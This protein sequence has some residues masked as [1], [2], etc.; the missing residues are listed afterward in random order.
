MLIACRRSFN[1]GTSFSKGTEERRYNQ[2][3]FF[4]KKYSF[5][6]NQNKEI[7]TESLK[8]KKG[9]DQIYRNDIGIE[10]SYSVEFNWD[11]FVV[12]RKAKMFERSAGI[13]PDAH[14][15]LV[16][17]SDNLTRIDVKMK[18][19]EIV[20][21]ILI[22]IQLGIIAGCLFGTNVNELNWWYRILMLIGSSGLFNFII[23]MFFIRESNVLKGVIKQLFE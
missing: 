16:H 23:W 5:E 13:E 6:V 10:S 15:R 1:D 4:R 3:M 14:I 12:T 21:I 19:S 18:F 20:W 8:N 22:F 11:E 7:L 9:K 17:L 2:I